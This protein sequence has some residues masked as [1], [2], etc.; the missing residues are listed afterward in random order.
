MTLQKT[1]NARSSFV[2]KI[3]DSCSASH[4]FTDVQRETYFFSGRKL[5]K[6]NDPS[7]QQPS[8]KDQQR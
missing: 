6:F 8:T 3:F 5:I 1:V 2:R 4:E 7:Q